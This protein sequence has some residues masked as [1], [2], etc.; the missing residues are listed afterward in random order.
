MVPQKIVVI[1]D[2][3]GTLTNH[4]S[5]WQ[6]VL[7]YLN[8]WENKGEKHLH[9]FLSN[10]IDYD[11]FIKKDVE[12]LK[13][14]PLTKYFEAINKISFREGVGELFTYFQKFNSVNIIVSSGLKDLADRLSTRISIKQIFANELNKDTEKLDGTYIKN[15]GW[16]DKQL[17]MKKLKLSYSNSFIIAFGDTNADLPLLENSN[18]GFSCCNESHVLN[19]KA[20]YIIS[21]LK[22]AIPLIETIFSE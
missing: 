12:L 4:T 10:E 22:D 16:N 21:D 6:F 8:L 9:Q 11:E 19:A 1:S 20:D 17:I 13:N 15:V 18:L 3:D 7:E 14:T 5:S 2:L